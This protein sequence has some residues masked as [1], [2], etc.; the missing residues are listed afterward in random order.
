VSDN[1]TCGTCLHLSPGKYTGCNDF[2]MLRE[3]HGCEYAPPWSGVHDTTKAC[4][5]YEAD[6]EKVQR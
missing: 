5:Q 2:P 3:I 6:P 4:Q 1:P